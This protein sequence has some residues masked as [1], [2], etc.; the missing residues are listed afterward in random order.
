MTRLKA[1]WNNELS[2]GVKI[3]LL[4]LLANGLPAFIILMSMPD[5]TDILFVWTSNPRSTP[6]W[7]A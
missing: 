4:T 5:K 2:K 3:V 1:W 7:L 6:V